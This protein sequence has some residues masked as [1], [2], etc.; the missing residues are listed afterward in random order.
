[1]TGRRQSVCRT[2]RDAA[3][4]DEADVD[5]SLQALSR[6]PPEIMYNHT[7]SYAISVY[8]SITPRYPSRLSTLPSHYS[9][10]HPLQWSR[11]RCSLCFDS[12]A[13]FRIVTALRSSAA[14]CCRGPSPLLRA[15]ILAIFG[16]GRHIWRGSGAAQRQKRWRY[17]TWTAGRCAK[18]AKY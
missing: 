3:A 15:T 10:A 18:Y 9:S 11:G 1:M 16:I 7:Q 8:R 12:V 5:A 17:Q 13:W 6:T 2:T 4:S 14:H